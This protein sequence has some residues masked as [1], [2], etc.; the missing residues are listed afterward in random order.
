MPFTFIEFQELLKTRVKNYYRRNTR[1]YHKIKY[2]STILSTIPVFYF[3]RPPSVSSIVIVIMDDQV[4]T[5]E[6]MVKVLRET[7]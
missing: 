6:T 5:P 4:S 2:S 7:F 1:W 3:E